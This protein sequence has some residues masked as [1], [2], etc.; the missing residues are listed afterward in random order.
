MEKININAQDKNGKTALQY[1]CESQ[2]LEV[3]KLLLEHGA[4]QKIHSGDKTLL[5]IAKDANNNELMTIL[6]SK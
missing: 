1:A 4:D 5:E 6:L 2:N 3:V